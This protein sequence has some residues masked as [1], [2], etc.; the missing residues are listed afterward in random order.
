ME[1]ASLW[2]RLQ[3]LQHE[4]DRLREENTRFREL[5]GISSERPEP[6]N[7]SEKSFH[8]VTVNAISGD[9]PAESKIDFF[10]NLFRGREDAYALRW[11]GQG[12][13]SGYTPA[14][15]HEWVRPLCGKPKIKCAECG[16]RVLSPLTNQIIHEH[17]VGKLTVGIYP[18]LPDETC[19]FLA[20]DFDK[21][22]WQEDTRAFLQTCGEMGVPAALERS[23]SGNGGH[24]WIFFAQPVPAVQARKL[25]CAV[26]TKA[27]DKR[28]QL[29]LDSYD[30]FFPNQDNMP[31]GGFGNLIALPL[32]RE[33][34]RLGNS[35]F[36]DAEFQ[37]HADQWAYLASL[38][39]MSEGEVDSIV[40]E[41]VRG[42]DILGV[43][44]SRSGEEAEEDPW[45]LPLSGKKSEGLLQCPLPEKVRLVRS[46]LLYIE[47]D[48]LHP[49]LLNR[50]VR[51]AAFQNPEFYKTQAMRLSTFG[52]PRIIG[53]AEDF[54]KYLGLP[55]GCLDE[56][57]DLLA[58]HG[59]PAEVADERFGG[60][61]VEMAFRGDLTDDQAQAAEALL[62]HDMGIL[63]AATGFGKTVVAAWMIAKR[64]VNTLV[65]VHRRQL[66]DQWKERLTTFLELAPGSIG[67]IGGGKTKPTGVIDV[68]VIQ[69][70]HRKGEVNDCLADY[71]QV[72]VDECH[73]LSAVSF[74][75]VLKGARA[76]YVVGL[77]A[78]PTRKDGHHPIV[79]MQCGPI[80]FRVTA[81]ERAVASE[82]VYEVVPRETDFCLPVGT[83]E[84]GIQEI[85]AALAKDEERN[86]LIF[87]DL[88]RATKAGRS[89]L[90]LTERTEHLEEF[91]RLLKDFTKNVIVLRGGMGTKQ[92]RAIAE[93]LAAIPEDEERVLL[94]TGR[95]IGEGFDDARL[96]T[97]FLTSPISWTGTLLQYAGRL[98]R[99]HPDKWLVQIYD[100]VDFNVPMLASMY[101][102]RLSGYK[103]MGYTIRTK[104]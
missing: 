9:A 80:R 43:R 62:V 16:H 21:A 101:R 52:V 31:K 68:G 65:L 12:G 38:R 41:A 27:M 89:P 37:P 6:L 29:G 102:K 23:R 10:R 54:P 60:T 95:Y 84:H 47:K 73:H 96:D 59:I 79:I 40:A 76:R 100:Y 81:K 57:L 51:M 63:A 77:T 5:L 34:R 22:T 69:S 14:C 44:M 11:E 78:T 93:R 91:S 20:V 70:L 3:E 45:T 64:R 1:E 50:L 66:L 104:I 42:G 33:P 30:R 82:I 86:G 74:E 24:V 98:H 18:L 75:K 46:N 7:H 97:L 28:N 39:R 15:Q 19:W 71:G 17:L 72:I 83:T 48:G 58:A 90:L 26:L 36:V 4:C 61:M 35:T 85:Y 13:R 32:Q 87:N 2:I 55:R 56:A 94:A 103:A 49:A 99:H 88:I 92:R 8:G 53:C 67:Q 25:G